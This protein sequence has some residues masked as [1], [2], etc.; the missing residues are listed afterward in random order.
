MKKNYISMIAACLSIMLLVPE[1]AI[2][3]DG[4]FSLAYGTRSKGMGGA[5]IALYETSLFG[6]NNPAGLVRYGKGYGIAAGLFNPNRSYTIT[7]EPSIPN[8]FPP[9]FGLAPGKVTSESKL[10]VMPSIAANFMVGSKN[11]L[12]VALYGN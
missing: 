5:G 3:T 1:Q 11:A 10:F 7:G 12:G 4:Y 9:A 2:A 6:A 8:S